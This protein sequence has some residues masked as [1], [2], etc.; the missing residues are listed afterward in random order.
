MTPSDRMPPTA[1]SARIWDVPVRLFH[2]LLVAL[3]GFSWW[4][5]DQHD[6]EW[7]RL[8][9]YAILTLVIFRIY[10]GFVGSHTARFT[11]F[12]RGP[13]TAFAYARSLA[14]G[15]HVVAHGHNPIGGWSVLLMLA[16]VSTMIVAGLFS[17]DVDGL[18]SGPL[19]DHVS[20]ET[21]RLAA[22]VHH[23]VFN[24][25][26][27]LVALHVLAILFY[28]VR[29]RL[30]LVTPMIH[31]RRR[32][33]DQEQVDARPASWWRAALGIGLA[34]ACTYAIANGSPF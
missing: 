25:L 4:S 24:V 16:T 33:C 28:L 23:V 13:R 8:S 11:Q 14:K 29:R 18:E 6:M 19:A 22:G 20:F 21:G 34:V 9:G 27:A 10:W 3:L 15:R 30:D 2:W 26:L 5:G 31:G 17:V 12:V 7:H 1:H 32:N